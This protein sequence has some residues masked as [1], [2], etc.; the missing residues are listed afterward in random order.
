MRLLLEVYIVTKSLYEVRYEL[1]NRP[2][3]VGWPLRAVAD[4]IE[5]GPTR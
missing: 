4:L 3:W 5:S 1:A 2:H